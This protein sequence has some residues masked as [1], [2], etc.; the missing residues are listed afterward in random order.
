VSSLSDVLRKFADRGDEG[1]LPAVEEIVKNDYLAEHLQG[2][3]SKRHLPAEELAVGFR[4]PN[5]FTKIRLASLTDNGW[6]LRLH[7]WDACSSDRDIHNHRWCFASYVLSGS[8]VERRYRSMEG[9]GQW[10][11]YECAPSF[12][13]KYSFDN[14]QSCDL[15]LI[16]E[17]IYGPGR[18]YQRRAEILHTAM[19]RTGLHPVITLFAQ[20]SVTRNSTAVIRPTDDAA[21]VSRSIVRCGEQDLMD[22][23]QMALDTLSNA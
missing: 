9:V 5:G 18:S 4:H 10:T 11:M 7:V 16:A 2:L 6:A 23:L 19:T 17:D 14:P 20:G 22:T 12:E 8:L 13:G 15:E 3:L 1:L 21:A